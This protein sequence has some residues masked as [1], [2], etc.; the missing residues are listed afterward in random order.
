MFF[1]LFIHW[2]NSIARVLAIRVRA[3]LEEKTEYLF[4]P[5]KYHHTCNKKKPSFAMLQHISGCWDCVSSFYLSMPLFNFQIE[6]LNL[7][8]LMSRESPRLSFFFSTYLTFEP[9]FLLDLGFAWVFFSPFRVFF[10]ICTCKNP[11][12]QVS[13]KKF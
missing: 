7:S 3:L 11:F 2:Y 5:N 8:K 13:K 9:F 4:F 10:N 12:T 1:I 6:T